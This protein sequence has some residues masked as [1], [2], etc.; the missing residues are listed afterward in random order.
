MAVCQK[1]TLLA[2]GPAF[3]SLLAVLALVSLLMAVT[4]FKGITL[5]PVEFLERFS[6][7]HCIPLL[8]CCILERRCKVF[9]GRTFPASVTRVQFGV[10]GA[11]TA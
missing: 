1:L 9:C 3:R 4:F 6:Y 7:R 5:D 2:Q 11:G 10:K 8:F